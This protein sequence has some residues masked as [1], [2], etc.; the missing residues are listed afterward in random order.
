MAAPSLAALGRILLNENGF[1]QE[2]AKTSAAKALQAVRG[3]LARHVKTVAQSNQ[4]PLIIATEK[5][6]VE[7]DLQR[8]AN[9][10]EM[11]KSLATALNELAVIEQHLAFMA[12]PTQYRAVNETHSL[13]RNRRGELPYDE[14]RQAMASR[15]TRLG[16]MDKSR[17]AAEEKAVLDARKSTLKAS[18]RLCEAMPSK[19][20]KQPGFRSHFDSTLRFHSKGLRP[21]HPPFFRSRFDSHFM[22]S[23]R[24]ITAAAF[25]A[26]LAI[27]LPAQAA[28]YP[29]T[30]DNCGT[31]LSFR[32]APKSAVAIGR[33]T[34]AR[35]SPSLIIIA[36]MQRHRFLADDHEKKLD[37]LKT[38]PVASQMQAVKAGRIVTVDADA[39]QGSIRMPD[40]MAQIAKAVLK[41]KN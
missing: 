27:S 28:S 14:A 10:P 40:G 25:I 7:G 17:L 34:I 30:I 5:T 18:Q 36:R 11:V 21:I 4:L 31:A 19:A 41:L 8:Y 6:I 13:P 3:E 26:S 23:R 24:L 32:Q 33:E 16:N 37:L 29:V 35:A 2:L 20:L 15:Q 39:L 1:V 9:S 38:D 12:D 22:P